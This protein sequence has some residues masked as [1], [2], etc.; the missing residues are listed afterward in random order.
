MF[1]QVLQLSEEEAIEAAESRDEYEACLPYE[2]FEEIERDLQ[3]YEI[4]SALC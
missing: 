3:D 1:L 4:V 2:K